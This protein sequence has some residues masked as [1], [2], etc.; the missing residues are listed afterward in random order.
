MVFLIIQSNSKYG[1]IRKKLLGLSFIAG[2]ALVSC[3]KNESNHTKAKTA[4]SVVSSPADQAVDPEKKQSTEEP[5]ESTEAPE[6][7]KPETEV[8]KKSVEGKYVAVGCDGGRFSIEFKNTD[9]NPVFKIYDKGKVIAAGNVSTETDEKTG[10]INEIDLG[11]IGGLYEG[12]KII[13]QNYGNAMNEFD[14]FT[15]CGDKY[16]EFTKSK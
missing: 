9:G 7:K 14:H 13:I 2:L 8:S 5:D 15:Q 3:N 1:M 6:E 12:D 10:E 16:L 4:S 11:D